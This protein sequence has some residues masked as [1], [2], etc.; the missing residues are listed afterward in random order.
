[1]QQRRDLKGMTR[2]E[3]EAFVEALGERAFRGRQIMRWI[4]HRGAEDFS[5]MSDLPK[6]L[7][8]RLSERARLSRLELIAEEES[9]DGTRKF[10][11]GLSDGGAIESVLI[12]DEDRLTLCVSTQVGCAMGCRFCLTARGGFARDLTA[13]EI[14]DQVLQVRR[15]LPSSKRI[16]NVVLM[17]M[18][19][20]LANYQE[21]VK[22]IE[23]MEDDLGL[24]LSARRITLSTVGLLPEL[25]RLFAD[26]V[27]CR[28]AI[29]LNASDQETRQRL[30]P[31]SKKY[32]LEQLLDVCR[33]LPLPPRERITFEYVLI[34]GVNSSPEDARRLASILKGIRCK[35]NLIPLNEAP[36]IPF[37]S[38]S[39]EEILEFQ[40]I[41]IDAGY[42]ALIRE[43]RGADISAACGQLRGKV[44]PGERRP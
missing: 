24:G 16:T 31:I 28:L 5:V 3:L 6:A 25:E 40:R 12:P 15:L 9:R 26:G 32:P 1:M 11:F 42:T 7:R 30:M 43:S 18:G 38:P 35:V 20:P 10:L 41:L 23:V 13:A 22:A 21:V 17:G 29:S 8:E 34:A 14:V 37:R 39:R 36:E 44:I 19:E 2:K 33:R 4:Y 27:R